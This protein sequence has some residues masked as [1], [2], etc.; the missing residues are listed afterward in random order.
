MKAI[1]KY[2]LSGSYE[3]IVQLPEN[4]QILTVQVQNDEMCLWAMINP[5]QSHRVENRTICIVPTGLVIQDTN[6]L[7]YI[8]TVQMAQGKMVFHIFEKV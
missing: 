3:Q 7:A 4:A 2:T 6:G 8:S 1:W 5:G